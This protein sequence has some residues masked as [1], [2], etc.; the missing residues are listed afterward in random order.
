[1][2]DNVDQI[3][4][5]TNTSENMTNEE[6]ELY[7]KNLLKKEDSYA[8]LERNIP[9]EI[10]A[11]KNRIYNNLY[12][13][14]KFITRLVDSEALDNEGMIQFYYDFIVKIFFEGRTFGEGDIMG[15]MLAQSR[16][17]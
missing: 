5:Y 1:M 15:F 3:T 11:E 12:E 13:T 7:Y 16:G 8:I 10:E 4:K 17:K 2:I 14:K 6:R 9:E